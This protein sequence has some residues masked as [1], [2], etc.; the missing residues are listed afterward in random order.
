[1]W[2]FRYSMRSPDTCYIPNDFDWRRERDDFGMWGFRHSMRSP[3]TCYIPNYFDISCVAVVAVCYFFCCAP[4]CHSLSSRYIENYS[5]GWQPT[6]QIEEVEPFDSLTWQ[7]TQIEEVESPYSLTWQP[8]QIEEVEPP[9]FLTWQPTQIEEVEPPYSLT[10][11]PH[12]ACRVG[13][14]PK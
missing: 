1:M 6:E 7:P 14:Q 11:P 3:D 2:G 12:M 13:S 10:S 5:S 4:H 9:Y 8:T